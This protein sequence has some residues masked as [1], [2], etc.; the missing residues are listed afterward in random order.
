MPQAIH[1][2][3]ESKHCV[4]RIAFLPSF[5]RT[6]RAWPKGLHSLCCIPRPV[7]HEPRLLT[8]ARGSTS[9]GSSGEQGLHVMGR[10]PTTRRL[11]L[12]AG[13]LYYWR[14]A[15]TR[16][17]WRPG[18]DS[19]AAGTGA[20]QT[21][22]DSGPQLSLAF[23]CTAR[24]LTTARATTPV[25]KSGVS[26]PGHAPARQVQH[27]PPDPTSKLGVPAGRA[28]PDATSGHARKLAS[29]SHN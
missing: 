16:A 9:R 19:T 27:D 21:R 10:P 1:L 28:T 17:F 15:R 5:P 4:H 12:R 18:A 25:T 7:S 11:R 6:T 3:R 29:G 24:P 14:R 2:A 22:T 13:P 26:K 20:R 23:M 8:P